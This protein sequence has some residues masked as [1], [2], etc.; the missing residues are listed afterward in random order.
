MPAP[1]FIGLDVGGTKTALVART[2]DTTHERAGEGTNLQRD[3]LQRSADV[4]AALV[5]DVL[6]AVEHDG[7]SICLGVA[8]AGR[9]ADRAALAEAIRERASLSPST[10]LLAV[11][12]D[13]HIAL[14][15]AFE[16]ESGLIVIAGTGSVVLARTEEGTMER[17]GGWGPRIG[18][19]GSGM[20]VGSAG[21][22]AVATA[23]DGGEP[24]VL[25]DRLAETYGI[26]TPDDLIHAVYAEGWTMQDV[27]PLVVAAAEAGDWACTRILKNQANALAQRAGWLVTRTA[28]PITPRVA[29]LG[30]LIEEAYYRT[31]LTEALQRHLPRWE[32]GRPSRRPVEGALAL[33]EQH[34]AAASQEIESGG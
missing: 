14:E 2:G 10:Y 18:D 31:C 21:L 25:R 15:A 34:A 19:E 7:G 23:F 16:G 29:L 20:A 17:A 33:A 9:P 22:G 11:E 4:L 3:G 13:A 8:G 32:V 26:T 27:A 5:T 30:G 1:L 24:T 28:E 12:H 6:A